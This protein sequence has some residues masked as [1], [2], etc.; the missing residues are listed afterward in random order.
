MPELPEVEIVR[1]SL[2][3]NIKGKK[4]NRVLVRNRNLRFKLK[5]YFKKRLENQFILNISRFSK[6]IIIMFQ[7]KSFCVIHLGSYKTKRI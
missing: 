3:R 4:I 2:L 1:Q 5:P 6:Y 7:N